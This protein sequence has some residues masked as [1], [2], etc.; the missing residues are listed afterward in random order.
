MNKARCSRQR[1]LK[2]RKNMTD[3]KERTALK[4]KGIESSVLFVQSPSTR[5]TVVAAAAARRET[6][7]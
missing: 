6:R 5:L 2:G 3:V 7:T 1:N 4:P